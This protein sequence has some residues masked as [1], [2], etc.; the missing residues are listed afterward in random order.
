M[1]EEPTATVGNSKALIGA[2]FLQYCSYA[3]FYLFD[4]FNSIAPPMHRALIPEQETNIELPKRF[5]SKKEKD[6]PAKDKK[7]KPKKKADKKEEEEEYDGG[8]K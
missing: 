6:G 7:D 4:E 5:N 2:I 3:I 8:S 1:S